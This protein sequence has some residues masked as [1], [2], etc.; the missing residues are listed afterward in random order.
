MMY[1]AGQKKH[2]GH[3]TLQT[4]FMHKLYK[5]KVKSSTMIL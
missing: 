4:I 5:N 3:V 2:T 1:K